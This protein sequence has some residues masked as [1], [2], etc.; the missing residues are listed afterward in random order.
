M[1]K[2]EDER[3]GATTAAGRGGV[4]GVKDRELL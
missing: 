3:A 2:G 4:G 1:T